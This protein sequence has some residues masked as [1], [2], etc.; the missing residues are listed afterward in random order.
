M[1]VLRSGIR[2]LVLFY[3]LWIMMTLTQN[4]YGE[5][6]R[7]G[8]GISPSF[9]SGDYRLWR[10]LSLNGYHETLCSLF[11]AVESIFFSL[12]AFLLLIH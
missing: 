11:F 3:F 12:V 6:Y 9:V 8:F 2:L 5:E 1:F 4:V 7:Y 10:D